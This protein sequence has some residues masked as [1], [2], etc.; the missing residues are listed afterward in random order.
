MTFKATFTIALGLS[1]LVMLPKC[2]YA[3]ETSIKINSL[4]EGQ[5]PKIII[6]SDF[7]FEKEISLKV[8][9]DPRY[10]PS[11]VLIKTIS[12]MG[13]CD[14]NGIS[15]T[16]GFDIDLENDLV[17]AFSGGNAEIIKANQNPHGLSIT[18]SFKD[19]QNS[20]VSPPADS[21][22]LY[23]TGG[24]RLAFEYSKVTKAPPKMAFVLLLDRSGSMAG[25]INDVQ[26]S[27]QDFLKTLPDSAECAV[28]SFNG[29]FSYHNDYYQSCNTGDF[30]LNSLTA[31][32]RTDLYTPLLNA[33][34][35]LS[36]EYFKDYQKAVIVITDGQIPPDEGLRTELLSAKQDVL[37]FVY[38]LGE[39]N[40]EQLVGL[41]NAFLAPS[42]DIKASLD[43]YFHS[44]GS[45]Y[46]NQTVLKVK[47]TKGGNYA[48]A[49]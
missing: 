46:N 23:N 48:K 27:A 14:A 13:M 49:K 7:D 33:Y 18:A 15:I 24:D 16:S 2:S 28:A 31:E 12:E 21:L 8:R 26:T 5:Y 9:P 29:T 19:K 42:S 32:G 34:E 39:K 40:D 1:L 43:Q 20:F 45:A 36:Q 4:T 6:R 44:L 25:V 38:F 10:I 11:D 37:T 22:A 41:A 47:R 35:S 30:Q 3:Q 17:L